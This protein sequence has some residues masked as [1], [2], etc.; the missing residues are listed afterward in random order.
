[1]APRAQQADL[2]ALVADDESPLYLQLSRQL[3]RAI[4]EGVYPVGAR[5]PTE[6]ELVERYGVSRHTVREALRQL[7]NEGLV[8]SKQGAG[9]T[10]SQPLDTE[11]DIH[12]VMS[13]NDLLAFAT[14]ACYDIDEVG[15][16]TLDRTAAVRTGLPEGQ[17]WLRVAGL[18]VDLVS[19]E[20]QCQ[21]EYYI[22]RDYASVG[23]I[24]P[25]H[26]GPVFP[27]LES[28]YGLRVVEVSQQISAVLLG[29]SLAHSLNAEPGSAALEVRRAYKT[30]DGTV[31]QV[32]VN[33]HPASRFKHVMTIRRVKG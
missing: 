28:L 16:Q 3:K 25:K 27:L 26:R 13:I 29:D 22:H 21:T 31:V 30:D 4:L 32:T 5:L 11:S 33:T 12:Q 17:Q 23:R 15:I 1:M 7:R 20:P 19:G 2:A 8:T 14:D 10:V 9:T 6:G 24:L 18:R